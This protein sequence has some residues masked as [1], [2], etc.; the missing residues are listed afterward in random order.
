MEASFRDDSNKAREITLTNR[1]FG[2]LTHPCGRLT[3]LLRTTTPRRLT[4]S[5]SVRP[6][7]VSG[8]TRSAQQPLPT[9]V[10]STEFR[11]VECP[12]VTHLQG[13]W[14]AV[15]V[16]LD[17]NELPPMMVTTG[18]RT[19]TQNQVKVTFAGQLVVNALVRSDERADPIHIDYFNQSGPAKGQ[20]QLGIPA[21][22]MTE[23]F[24]IGDES[25]AAEPEKERSRHS[26]THLWGEMG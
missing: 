21:M 15:Q 16:V 18:V 13:N 2:R 11:Y 1:S 9:Q 17:G 10:D 19:A 4:G 25:L 8:G 23:S 5:S 7:N 24:A 26:G 20:V 12:T 3:W 14:A 6:A 22:A